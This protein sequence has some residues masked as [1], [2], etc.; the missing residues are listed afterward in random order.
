MIHSISNSPLNLAPIPWNNMP[1]N[2]QW[3]GEII[4][5]GIDFEYNGSEVFQLTRKK[6]S[7][8]IRVDVNYSASKIKSSKAKIVVLLE[9]PHLEEF[10]VV[11]YPYNTAPAWGNTGDRFDSQFI[12]VLNRHIKNI[13]SKYL[14]K[15]RQAFDVY[16]VNAIQYQC[17]LGISPINPSVRNGLF[18]Y[19][20]N[21]QPDSFYQDL[22]DRLN[23]IRPDIII[24]ACTAKLKNRH[25]N[26]NSIMPLLNNKNI[27]FFTAS[28][29]MSVWGKNTKLF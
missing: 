1:C 24:N 23:F 15:N 16:I 5:N 29:H 18:S 3:V 12:K 7:G 14:L 27:A 20:W 10:K 6:S 4:F 22:I 8:Q 9:S 26:A 25:C 28:S 2:D 11:G 21:L 19:L 13:G 17:S